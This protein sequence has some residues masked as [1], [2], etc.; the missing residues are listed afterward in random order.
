MNLHLLVPD[1]T[2]SLQWSCAG[3]VSMGQSSLSGRREST[4]HQTGGLNVVCKE[5]TPYYYN[6]YKAQSSFCV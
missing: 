1:T 5:I 2:G 4:Q 6:S 3:H